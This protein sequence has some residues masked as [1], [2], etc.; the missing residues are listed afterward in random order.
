MKAVLIDDEERSIENLTLLL[1]K[2]CPQVTVQATANNIDKG[3]Q[4]I[5]DYQPDVVFL[6]I[7]MPPY[8][9]FDLLRR[10]ES[11]PFEVIFV[12]AYD[13]YAID[14]IKFS[15]LYYIMKPIKIEELKSAVE[16]A[17]K[18][19]ATNSREVIDFFKHIPNNTAVL[20]RIVVNT[21]GETELIDLQ[22]IVY[23]KSDN[24]YST[25]HLKS[26]KRI[27]C[28]QRSIKDY[29]EMLSG[30]GFFRTHRSYIV[31]LQEVN[32]VS[33]SDGLQ[34]LL[35]NKETIPLALRR[36]NDFFD[37]L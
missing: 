7:D 12:T 20:D 6:D 35:K 4:L 13:F 16:K 2:Y 18:K 31:N 25:F 14:A 29:E 30:K 19:I 32:S 23:I 37:L 3:G 11:L 33:K 26:Q 15:A 9:G 27:T 28:S 1:E 22:D 21:Q 5:A 8:T 10:Y 34:I 24:V 17:E 36:K